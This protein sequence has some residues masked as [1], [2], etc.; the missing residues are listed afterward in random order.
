VPAVF[1]EGRDMAT[2]EAAAKKMG[3]HEVK[4]NDDGSVTYVMDKK[5]H[6][7]VLA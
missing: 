2:A 6:K 7:E 4:V 3:I 5:T 1:F